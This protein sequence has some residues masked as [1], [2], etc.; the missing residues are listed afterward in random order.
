[1]TE[2]RFDRYELLL[3]IGFVVFAFGIRKAGGINLL[4]VGL[5]L[6]VLAACVWVRARGISR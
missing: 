6:G 4:W 2:S 5:G 3:L 1:M